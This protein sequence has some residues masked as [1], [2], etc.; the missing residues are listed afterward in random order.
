MPNYI[1]M[2]RLHESGF[3]IRKIAKLV[4]SGRNTVTS[5]IR[6]A[7]KQQLSYQDLQLLDDQQVTHLF[8]MKKKSNLLSDNHYVMPNYEQLA[9]ELV[10]PGVTM[11]LLWEEY[12]QECRLNQTVYYK[13]TQFKKYFKD[14]L[15]NQTFRHVLHHKAGEQVQ[16]DWAGTK[17]QWIDPLVG[18]IIKGELFVA[19]LPFSHYTYAQACPDQKMSSWIDAHIKMFHFFNGVPTLL[20]P[21][22]LRTG[23]TKQTKEQLLLNPTYEDL[24]KHYQTIIVPTRVAH[25]RDK[26]AV[27][28]HVKH[29]T[30]FLIGRMRNFQ[31]FTIQEYN[32]YLQEE[33]T[34]FNQKSFQK[35]QEV[36]AN[37]LRSLN[38][39]L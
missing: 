6:T 22:N 21:D 19:T 8:Q 11:Q 37:C 38:K 26:A 34:K 30:T 17:P 29:L 1:E 24:A 7:A 23:V 9:K 31:C 15:S 5:A 14:Y 20:V 36:V 39:L 16:V 25:P 2:I 3:S 13:L 4:G 18:E 12:V 33:L 28:N 35:S 27:E 32:H 10:K